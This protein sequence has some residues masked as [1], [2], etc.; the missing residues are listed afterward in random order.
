MAISDSIADFLTRIR[1]A[2]KAQHRYVDVNWSRMNQA[3][4]EILK[5]QGFVESFLVKHDSDSRGTIRMFLKYTDNRRAV[6]QGI[7]RVSR[8]G[9]RR[10]VKFYD[11]PMFYGG[12]GLS[13]ISTSQGVM[14]GAEASKRRIG[15][16]LLCMVW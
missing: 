9:L 3:I 5:G 8:P 1:N 15:G 10:Y 6:I 16:E 12:L 11:I 13:I 14:D 4:A 2:A 7:K